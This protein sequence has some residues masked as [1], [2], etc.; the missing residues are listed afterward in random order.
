MVM[1]SVAVSYCLAAAVAGMVLLV[2]DMVLCAL[3]IKLVWF[4]LEIMCVIGLLLRNLTWFCVV[5]LVLLPCFVLWHG[6]VSCF[7]LY[8]LLFD[9]CLYCW[10]RSVCLCILILRSLLR[11]C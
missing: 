5:D 1:F 9:C 7:F 3:N 2:I 4:C 11:L 6:A 10:H 8:V